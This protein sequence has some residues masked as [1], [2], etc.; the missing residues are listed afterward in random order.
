[1][2]KTLAL[3]I[4]TI[5]C[6]PSYA[7]G[8]KVGV[9]H[10]SKAFDAYE[11]TKK[12][13]T[14]L[15]ADTQKKMQAAKGMRDDINTLNQQMEHN[16]LSAEK[17]MDIKEK[18]ELSK[19]KYDM[20]RKRTMALAERQQIMHISDVYKDIRSAINAYAKQNGYD[21]IIRLQPPEREHK[22]I[23]SLE[24]EINLTTV[25]YA[26]EKVD[27]TQAVIESLNKAYKQQ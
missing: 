8:L 17:R 7:E 18:L 3:L 4:L 26:G 12:L 5:I 15:K 11:K 1:M 14:Q 10:L 20:F 27:I 21:L 9:V 19:L 23:A 24:Q 2:K 16:M 25:L 13:D 22:D 6:V